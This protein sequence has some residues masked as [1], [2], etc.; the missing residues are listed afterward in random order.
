MQAILDHGICLSYGEK[1]FIARLELEN[2]A[3]KQI[4][5]T[6]IIAVETA[7]YWDKMVTVLHDMEWLYHH[8]HPGL[9]Q[10]HCEE[11]SHWRFQGHVKL[12]QSF[13]C[14]GLQSWS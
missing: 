13:I 4:L 2:G 11:R 8:Q 1:M 7:R 9:V 14:N 12:Y 5:L 6:E 3:E 10:L